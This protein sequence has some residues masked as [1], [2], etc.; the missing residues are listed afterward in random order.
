MRDSVPQDHK[1][2]LGAA[3]WLADLRGSLHLGWRRC[4]KANC[5]CSRGFLHGPYVVRRWR[6]DGRQRK[7]L[8]KPEDVPG[9]LAAVEERRAHGSVAQIVKSLRLA[10]R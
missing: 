9:V 6:E 8:V 5:R 3:P 10:R 7:V 2:R 1:L 4:G